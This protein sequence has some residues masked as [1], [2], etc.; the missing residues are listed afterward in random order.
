MTA[1]AGAAYAVVSLIVLAVQGAIV[2]FEV[3]T[4]E[5]LL[6][7]VVAQRPAWV[8]AQVALAAVQA[9]LVPVVIALLGAVAASPKSRAAAAGGAAFFGLAGTLL[10]LSGVFHGVLGVHLASPATRGAADGAAL[11]RDVA[12]VHAFG[13]TCYFA[14]TAALGIGIVV[15][16][17]AG[18]GDPR[19]PRWS[20]PLA[21]AAA[22]VGVLQFAWF[23]VPAAAVFAPVAALA[24]LVWIAGAGRAAARPL[25]AVR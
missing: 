7:D 23:A 25:E 22:V 21:H 3:V 11:L 18:R 4:P 12:L 6:A 13:D 19:L 2:H 20:D 1:W 8:A 9:L 17:R 16:A 10:V 15:L 24:Q 5:E 14:G